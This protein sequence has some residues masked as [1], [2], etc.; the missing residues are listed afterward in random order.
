[1]FLG[2]LFM[3]GLLLKEYYLY[4]MSSRSTF[5]DAV[6]AAIIKG[7]GTMIWVSMPESVTEKCYGC[8]GV[9]EEDGNPKFFASQTDH[10]VC[11]MMTPDE[12]VDYI[13]QDV[14]HKILTDLELAEELWKRVEVELNKEDGRRMKEILNNT[15]PKDRTVDKDWA[16]KNIDKIT[17]YTKFLLKTAEHD[18]ESLKRN[19]DVDSD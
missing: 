2:G 7:L 13:S 1:M 10:D 15:P 16:R 17:D 14:I 9:T 8:S 12:Q 3:I 4:N 6:N 19:R 11:C 18:Q 5:Y